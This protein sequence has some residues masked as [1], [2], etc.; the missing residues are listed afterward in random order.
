MYSRF[1][2]RSIREAENMTDDEVNYVIASH[3]LTCHE[4]YIE[5]SVLNHGLYGVSGRMLVRYILLPRAVPTK[6]RME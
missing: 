1:P 2:E 5:L 3:D 6:P 4:I